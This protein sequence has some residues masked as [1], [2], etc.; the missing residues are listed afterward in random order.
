MENYKLSSIKASIIFPFRVEFLGVFSKYW[1]SS[2]LTLIIRDKSILQFELF[3]RIARFTE[4]E[5][6][7]TYRVQRITA[8]R[9]TVRFRNSV[10]CIYCYRKLITSS[11]VVRMRYGG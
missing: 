5:Q 2:P 4:R 6:A 10:F 9:V 11:Q 7:S 8:M 3:L 1:R